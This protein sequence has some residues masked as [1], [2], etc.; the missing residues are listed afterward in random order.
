MQMQ[1]YLDV[2]TVK[3]LIAFFL[4]VRRVQMIKSARMKDVNQNYSFTDMF[5]LL[6]ALV[7]IL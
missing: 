3:L 1:S 5:H 2:P 7:M 4:L 6:I